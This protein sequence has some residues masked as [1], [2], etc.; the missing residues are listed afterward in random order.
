MV[1]FAVGIIIGAGFGF[2]LAV[3]CVSASS[4]RYDRIDGD[5]EDEK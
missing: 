4:S 1:A 2:T 5:N 3:L